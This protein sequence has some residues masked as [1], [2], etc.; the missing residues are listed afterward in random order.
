MTAEQKAQDLEKR[1]KAVIQAVRK[2]M[3][4]SIKSLV[5]WMEANKIK[6][7]TGSIENCPLAIAY[8]KSLK[9]AFRKKNITVEV[10]SD[11]DVSIT[12][13][14]EVFFNVEHRKVEASFIEKFDEEQFP[15]LVTAE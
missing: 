1:A 13:G 9:K 6:G 5:A 14:V 8:K 10:D 7:D 15:Q 4:N 12:N 11:L 3:G 2:E